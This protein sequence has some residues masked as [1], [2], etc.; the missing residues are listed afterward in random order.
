MSKG[1]MCYSGLLRKNDHHI[2]N[3]IAFFVLMYLLS[4]DRFDGSL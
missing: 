1:G 4:L 3:G 2:G